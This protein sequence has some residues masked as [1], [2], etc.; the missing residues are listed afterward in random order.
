M[1]DLDD[2]NLRKLADKYRDKYST[3]AIGVILS[4]GESIPVMATV[5]NDLVKQ[6]IKAGDLVAYLS[7]I[8]GAKGGGSPQLAVGGGRLAGKVDEALNSVDSW[9]SSK[10]E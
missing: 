10:L 9:L 7:G 8:L 6:G 4:T 3:H 2:A 5:T 1:A